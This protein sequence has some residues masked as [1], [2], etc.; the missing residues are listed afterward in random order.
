MTDSE[1][2]S[3]CRKHNSLS[4]AVKGKLEVAGNEATSINGVNVN[5]K[6]PKHEEEQELKHSFT[7]KSSSTIDNLGRRKP[8]RSFDKVG[9]IVL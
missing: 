3:S 2:N 4:E 1:N 8:N 7:T 9:R 6:W 5:P